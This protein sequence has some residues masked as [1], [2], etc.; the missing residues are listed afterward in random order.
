MK[1]GY[2]MQAGAPDVR[3]KPL[4]GPAL[5]VKQVFT[6][7]QSLGHQVRL[8]AFLDG[9]IWKSD[10]LEHYEVVVISW[11]DQG[12]LR[13]FE[14]FVRRI[15]SE[16]RLPYAALFESFRFSQACHQELAGFDL[17]YE[18][19]GWVGYGGGLATRWM[20]IPLILEVNGD[21]L[22][23]FEQLGLAPEGG[24]RWL[25]LKLMGWATRQAAH[26]VA[27]GEGWRNKFIDR[28][29]IAPSKV[30]VIEN[31]SQ[32]VDLLKRD[33]LRSFNSP[34]IASEPVNLIYIG[35]FEPWH[36]LC[37][38]VRATAKLL[39]EGI[40]LHLLLIGSGRETDEIKS[41][42]QELGLAG[43]VTFTGRLLPAQLVDYLS[44]A[45]IAFSPYCGRVEFSGLKLLDY[46]AAALATIASGEN[47][48][49]SVLE[50]GRTGWIVAPCDVDAL[51]QAMLML[52]KDIDLR[53]RMG[54][55]SRIEA[56]E[57]HSWQH[58]AIELQDLFHQVMLK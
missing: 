27:T 49:P 1:I 57:Q 3:N 40:N 16:L 13:W 25:S 14:R 7:L 35:G 28:W 38:L 37:V 9:Q 20:S 2:L 18:R 22:S 54:R 24:Q 5:H 23:E 6:E 55:E 43:Y 10:D 30:T 8:L 51:F 29:G 48:Q 41:L 50:H 19:M 21:H 39:A 26:V 53:K 46:K 44:Q 32:F 47:G 34:Q 17:L 4:S 11:L 15:Q 12:P 52:A 36:G 58:T 33:Q 42:T 56:E 45:D 31:G